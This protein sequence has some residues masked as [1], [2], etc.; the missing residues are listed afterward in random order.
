MRWFG[1]RVLR[2]G[3][4]KSKI[5]LLINLTETPKVNIDFQKQLW[6]PNNKGTTSF[7]RWRQIYAIA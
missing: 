4:E 1:K 2:A 6:R 3:K 7:W 5:T